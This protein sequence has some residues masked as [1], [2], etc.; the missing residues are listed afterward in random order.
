[1]EKKGVLIPVILAMFAASIYWWVLTS[2]ERSLARMQESAQVLVAKYDL[3][4]RT[5]LKEDL[6]EI[7]NIPR[8]YMQQDSQEI[9]SASDIKL[10]ANLVTAVRIPK[11]NQITLSALVSL[12]PEAGL[13]VKVPPGYR[14][15]ALPLENELMRLIKPGDRVDLRRRYG[16]QQERKSDRHHP[17]ERAG[18]WRRYESGAGDVLH[19]GQGKRRAGLRG[20][21]FLRQGVPEPGA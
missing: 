8:Q 10:I 5:I 7:V 17:S 2:K 14:G 1:M 16:R 13:S 11:G 20:P 18:A 4:A 12:S 9:R 6:V 15:C 3:P 21:G 19:P